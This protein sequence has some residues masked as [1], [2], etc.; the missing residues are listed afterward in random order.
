MTLDGLYLNLRSGVPLFRQMVDQIRTL[1]VSGE[2]RPG[3][4]L[5]SVRELAE[6]LSVTPTTV[7]K[8]FGLLETEGLIE[9]RRG[10]GMFVREDDPHAVA[11]SRRKIVTDQVTQAVMAA[12][13]IH[14]S[15]SE[16]DAIVDTVWKK[17]IT[18]EE[19]EIE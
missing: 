12:R 9:R 10:L 19:E 5:T 13:L 3:E 16:W 1:I 2:L 6:Q 7:S 8:V 11:V 15:R 4:Q 17:V 18:E 14:L